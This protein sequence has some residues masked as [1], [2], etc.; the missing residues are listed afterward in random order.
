MA[1]DHLRFWLAQGR[2]DL[3]AAAPPVPRRAWLV[4]AGLTL[5]SFLLLLGD[6]AIA[7]V[8]PRIQRDLRLG[9][10]LTTCRWVR[11]ICSTIRS[12]AGRCGSSTSSRGCLGTDAGRRGSTL[13][14]RYEP[15]AVRTTSTRSISLGPA[16]AEHL[17]RG[18]P[19]RGLSAQSTI[20]DLDLSSHRHRRHRRR[21]RG[22]ERTRYESQKSTTF[23]FSDR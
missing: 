4:L 2:S 3:R 1:L 9:G 19:Q 20:R 10:R 11:S 6:T 18:Q 12:Y 14:T 17:P 16:T 5:V 13:S 15:R 7:V 23:A 8:L 22:E 21:T